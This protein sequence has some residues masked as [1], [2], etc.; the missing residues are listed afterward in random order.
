M[1]ATLLAFPRRPTRTTTLTA[2][3]RTWESLCG[4][5]RVVEA[6][7]LYG[8]PTIWYAMFRVG[9]SSCTWDIISRHRA[10]PAAL[11]SCRKHVT[12]R[13][14]DSR[15]PRG[16][17]GGGHRSPPRNATHTEGYG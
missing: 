1:A 14:E 17:R 8:L 6:K 10:G 16:R 4:R 9:L 15:E 3:K 5:Y 12:D 11:A 7:S 2:R 13:K